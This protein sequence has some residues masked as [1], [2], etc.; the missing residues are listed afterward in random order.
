M[1][2]V[3]NIKRNFP[4]LYKPESNKVI[5]ALLEAIGQEDD[6]VSAQILNAKEQLFIKTAIGNY[7]NA[8]GSNVG[9][10]R[11]LNAD[12]IISN[13][14]LFRQLIPILS[15]YPKQIKPTIKALLDA[16]YGSNPEVFIRE[17][18]CDEIVIHLP[19]IAIVLRNNNRGAEHFHTYDGQVISINNITK[20]ITISFSQEETFV[21]NYFT[22][23]SFSQNVN[24]LTIVS[25]TA[26]TTN[27]TLGFGLSDDLSVFT[28][29]D[30]FQILN[31]NYRGSFIFSPGY[32]IDYTITSKRAVLN[33]TIISGSTGTSIQV[34]N[35]SQIPNSVGFLSF[36]YGKNQEEGDVSYTAVGNSTHI[37]IDPGYTFT[38]DHFPGE[39]IN[40]IT[41]PETIPDAD[42]SDYAVY[43]VGST[44]EEVSSD[45]QDLIKSIVAAG[46]IIRYII[47]TI[48]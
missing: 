7:L 25:S 30:I 4:G 23:K 9:I 39:V 21:L 34:I 44:D 12:K 38:K 37:T 14:D 46:I 22:G 48:A 29:S 15:F 24:S 45:V 20:E 16:F 18:N 19:S 31:S 17:I 43:V 13:D 27:I 47:S 33:D 28:T 3:I 41:Q 42:G 32:L 1:S 5:K 40:L 2:K 35:S 26:G 10:K 6:N 36:D 11:P 8:L